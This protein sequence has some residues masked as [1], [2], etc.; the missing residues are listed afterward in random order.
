MLEFAV[1]QKIE[2]QQESRLLVGGEGPAE[3]TSE[4]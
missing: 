2:D 3:Q 1:D 4:N